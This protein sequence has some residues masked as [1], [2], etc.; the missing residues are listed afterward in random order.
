MMPKYEFLDY[1]YQFLNF[2]I[3]SGIW[4]HFLTKY[5][6]LN[7][8]VPLM[9]NLVG[10]PTFNTHKYY[11]FALPIF[12]TLIFILFTVLELIINRIKMNFTITP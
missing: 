5:Q 3:L 8:S 6:S 10:A 12:T 1:A 2:I 11:L 4:T 9:F 7:A